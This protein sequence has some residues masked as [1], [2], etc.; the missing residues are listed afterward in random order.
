MSE[1]VNN[2]IAI[3]SV[4]D[5]DK[6]RLDI[7]KNEHRERDVV[8]VGALPVCGTKTATNA[9]SVLLCAGSSELVNR[10]TLRV[11]NLSDH[12]PCLIGNT[13]TASVVETG[14]TLD[15]GEEV[16]FSFSSTSYS[17]YARSQGYAVDLMIWES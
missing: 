15:P 2:L 12:V 9:V 16:T 8:T 11:K 14:Y 6:M 3:P 7:A 13:S 17:L 4:F 1:E 10:K 5:A